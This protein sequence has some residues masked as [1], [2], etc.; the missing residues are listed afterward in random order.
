MST[1]KLLHTLPPAVAGRPSSS[2]GNEDNNY[3][4][5][6]RSQ[7]E[8]EQG[9][10]VNNRIYVGGLGDCIGERDL[11]H[12]FSKF[13]S[14]QHVGIITTGGY[15]KGYGFVTFHNSEVV[16][17]ILTNP[18]KD[19][20][21]L[22]GRKLFVG[23]ARQRSSQMTNWG[24]RGQ[25]HDLHGGDEHGG[26]G[27]PN[28]CKEVD[29]KEGDDSFQP[30]MGPQPNISD[31]AST[32]TSSYL[33][34]P[35][36]YYYQDTTY[37]M[38]NY[39]TYY[40]PYHHPVPPSYNYNAAM[41]YYPTNQYQDPAMLG[42]GQQEPQVV[43][44]Y[45]QD[46]VSIPTNQVV[47]M[48]YH[49]I[50]QQANMCTPVNY[51][52]QINMI[53][54]YFIN[55]EEMVP[56]LPPPQPIMAYQDQHQQPVYQEGNPP[57]TYYMPPTDVGVVYSDAGNTYATYPSSAQVAYSSDI[58]ELGDS[59]FQDSSHGDSMN[60]NNA[61]HSNQSHNDNDGHGHAPNQNIPEREGRVQGQVE[62]GHGPRSTT[63]VVPDKSR[64]SNNTRETQP[65]N[66]LK[67][68]PSG[69]SRGPPEEY[70]SSSKDYGRGSRG[71]PM[72]YRSFPPFPR[73]I[74]PARQF[75]FP[76]GN[77]RPWYQQRGRGRVWGHNAGS[78]VEGN[79]RWNVAKRKPG[80]KMVG[81]EVKKVVG[82]EEAKAGLA[83][84]QPDILQG[85][86]EKLEIK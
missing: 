17:R 56:G 29:E 12:F 15:T 4:Q 63:A 73:N 66:L 78:R 26:Q 80:K 38:A 16:G 75:P 79:V 85:P 34:N 77:P 43:P 10:V 6:Y 48:P 47:P 32:G 54:Q 61:V 5:K 28:A 40:Q 44:S 42:Q 36:A 7:M 84:N 59:G 83:G 53:P 33:F 20:L 52:G 64:G 49:P 37:P 14:V 46:Q 24:G 50:Q 58:S 72:H 2:R 13:G 60:I 57:S 55:T 81:N 82:K 76:P 8:H 18:D 86:L 19:N 27:E 39:P 11:F 31:A 70:P 65:R 1:D 69:E 23:A 3:R 22:K 62:A 41:V 25:G 51:Y 71:A 68:K 74:P 45:N 30:Q 35:P 9:E 21:V 67:P